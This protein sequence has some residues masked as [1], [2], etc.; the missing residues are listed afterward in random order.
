MKLMLLQLGQRASE[1]NSL[2]YRYEKTRRIIT[3]SLA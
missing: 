1:A 2:I 3:T